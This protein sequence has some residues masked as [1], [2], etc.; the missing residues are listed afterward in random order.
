MTDDE[1]ERALLAL[2]LEEPPAGL[3]ERILAATVSRAPVSGPFRAWELWLIGA[4]VLVAAAV[5]YLMLAS[6]PDL[7]ARA[8]LALDNVLYALGL[9]SPATYVWCAVGVSAVWAISSLPL[10]LPARRTVYNR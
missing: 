10:M 1:L 5:T 8:N 4:A 2:P 9:F 7:G 3:R 6:V